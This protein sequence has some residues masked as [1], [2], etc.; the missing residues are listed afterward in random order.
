M[1]NIVKKQ[2]IFIFVTFIALFSNIHLGNAQDITSLYASSFSVR[3]WVI[4]GL[5]GFQFL[6]EGTLD[7]DTY[8]D[9]QLPNSD[10][11]AG[12]AYG[13]MP[14]FNVG[15]F[16]S[17]NWFRY[18]SFL[19]Y[20]LINASTKY[21]YDNNSGRY[22][23][24]HIDDIDNANTGVLLEV[25]ETSNFDETHLTWNTQPALGNFLGFLNVT[26]STVLFPL[27]DHRYIALIE[28]DASYSDNNHTSFYSTN[29]NDVYFPIYNGKP[30]P[31]IGIL[32]SKINQIG[33]Y[34]SIQTNQ[35]NDHFITYPSDFSEMRLNIGDRIV[36][37]YN[38]SS[39]HII[40][41]DC[42]SGQFN[43]LE[44]PLTS[45]GN[46]NFA[47]FTRNIIINTSIDINKMQIS[48][49]LNDGNR[50]YL[51]SVEIIRPTFSLTEIDITTIL[52]LVILSGSAIVVASII[53]TYF[54]RKEK[55]R[56]PILRCVS[57]RLENCTDEYGRI[58]T[59][60]YGQDYVDPF[61]RSL[62]KVESN[63]P[64]EHFEPYE[65]D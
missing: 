56:P 35:D 13:N 18:R 5:N 8:V 65:L 14:I 64:N 27:N 54:S 7:K 4:T 62:R 31:Q 19:A 10:N 12:T 42:F 39:S 26:T 40:N 9:E 60:E 32:T 48:G 22:L 2:L 45:E 51:K 34:L 37:N 55:M 17:T 43:K 15:W 36:L 58:Y 33:K 23:G 44:V 61:G 6:T 24:L 20:P 63:T 29:V 21:L 59:N 52:F 57:K 25:Y 38:S 41:L 46:N 50:F 47:D 1:R 11:I 28:H 16:Y 49:N 3:P 30:L 53:Y